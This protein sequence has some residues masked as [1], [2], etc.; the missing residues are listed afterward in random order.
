MLCAFAFVS[1]SHHYSFASHNSNY[2]KSTVENILETDY[3][4]GSVFR[5]QCYIGTELVNKCLWNFAFS[6]SDRI[7]ICVCHN[8]VSCFVLV[9]VYTSHTLDMNMYITQSNVRCNDILVTSEY[10]AKLPL[11]DTLL[12]VTKKET[13]SREHESN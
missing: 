11:H 10:R 13:Y 3:C 4:S 5:L 1:F 9:N 8:A 6:L 7:S 2:L 12:E